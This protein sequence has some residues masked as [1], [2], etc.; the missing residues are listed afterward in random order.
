MKFKRNGI[1]HL[2]MFHPT[3]IPDIND[4]DLWW[5]GPDWLRGDESKWPIKNLPD[6]TPEKLDFLS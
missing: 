2:A 3:K 6:I 4:C 5:Y 1:L